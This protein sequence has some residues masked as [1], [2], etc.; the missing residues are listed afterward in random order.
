[1]S[2][3]ADLQ[4]MVLLV[5]RL[6]DYISSSNN[7]NNNNQSFLFLN[8]AMLGNSGGWSVNPECEYNGDMKGRKYCI[9]FV[10]MKF[11]QNYSGKDQF[12]MI[13]ENGGILTWNL[14][15][16]GNDMNYTIMSL[17]E[18]NN[19]S[20]INVHDEM[21]KKGNIQGKF[22]DDGKE[23]EILMTLSKLNIST[24]KEEIKEG[25]YCYKYQIT[26]TS[27]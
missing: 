6:V 4:T 9:R 24:R 17:D 12:V 22:S 5:D 7:N 3:T 27:Q 8:A 14:I 15:N 1:M 21:F 10:E 2:N 13:N 25:P 11:T 18:W 20:G 26:R 16:D 23:F 19:F